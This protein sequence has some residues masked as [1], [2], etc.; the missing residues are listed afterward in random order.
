MMRFWRWGF[1]L[2]VLV[3]DVVTIVFD[4]FG[5]GLRWATVAVLTAILL[6]FAALRLVEWRMNREQQRAAY[7]ALA[8]ADAARSRRSAREG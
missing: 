3:L 5:P 1:V 7:A 8:R 6:G 2:L 4:L